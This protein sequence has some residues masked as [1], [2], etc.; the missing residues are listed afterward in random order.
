MD[1]FSTS[2]IKHHRNIILVMAIFPMVVIAI[3]GGVFFF[4]SQNNAFAATGPQGTKPT[5]AST[6]PRV[7]TTNA[8]GGNLSGTHSGKR[9]IGSVTANGPL[10]LTDCVIEGSLMVNN[11]PVL[12]DHCDIN[13][14]Y[15]VTT[16]NTDPNKAILTMRY[17]KVTGPTDNDTMRIGSSTGWGDNTKYMNTLMED[18]IIYS[19]FTPDNPDAHFDLIQFGGGR[20]STF[21][22]VVFSFKPQPY[23]Y[24]FTHFINNGTNNVNV[25]MQDVWFEGGP[26]GYTVGG[27]M[28]ITNCM[29]ARSTAQFGYVYP[30]SGS[31][32]R[33]CVNDVG[34]SI[35]N[36]TAPTPPPPAPSP[37]P[38][39]PAPAPPP[40][41]PSV[42]TTPPPPPSSINPSVPNTPIA[43]PGAN[44]DRPV[45]IPATLLVQS[46]GTVVA[47]FNGDGVNE[48]A[49]DTDNDGA[50]NPVTEILPRDPSQIPPA[51]VNENGQPLGRVSNTDIIVFKAG[52]LP[53]VRV[54]KPVG[55]TFVAVQG[56]AITTIGAYFALT[57]LAIFAG[58]RSKLG[59]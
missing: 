49:R 54:S 58:F 7:A 22:R 56:L 26:V 38:P 45:A 37:M 14:W 43:V 35:S 46:D 27:P 53:E 39:A 1:S 34:T 20:N 23:H 9:F 48:A 3:V 24:S 57:K 2:N 42:P 16:A 17:S 13:G 18:S 15:G 44:P 10:T 50:I 31:Q 59:L 8:S 4:S 6:G 41:T 5:D 30:S 19:P 51:T 40:T 36:S 47:D 25:V 32:L 28:I 12:I 52:P 33:N 55:Y 11:G 21:N 29:I